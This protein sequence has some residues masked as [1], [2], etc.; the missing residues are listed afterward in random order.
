MG[1]EPKVSLVIAFIIPGSHRW[2]DAPSPYEE[3]RSFHSHHFLFEVTLP[4]DY[5]NRQVEFIEARRILVAFVHDNW[6]YPAMFGEKSC[7]AIAIDL[8]EHMEGDEGLFG[9]H[10]PLPSKIKVMEDQFVG[11]EVIFDA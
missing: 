10:F 1:E 6:G 7:E 2:K 3:L 9:S 5:D 4:V 8:R 11:A